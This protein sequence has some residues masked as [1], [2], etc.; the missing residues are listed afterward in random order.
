MLRVLRMRP[1]TPLLRIGCNVLMAWGLLS[2]AQIGMAA[3]AEPT[4]SPPPASNSLTDSALNLTQTQ[5]RTTVEWLAREVDSWFGDQ[6]FSEGGKVT[7]GEIGW[8]IAKRTDQSATRAFRFTARLR[9]PNL[10]SHKSL[11]IGSDDRREVLTDR[12]DTL[13]RQ[14]QLL[15]DDGRDNTF[16]AGIGA[17]LLDTFDLRAGFRG[18]LKPYVQGRYKQDWAL[19]DADHADFR[20]TFFYSRSDRLGSTT[21]L[22]LRHALSTDLNVRWL[23]AITATQDSRD[24]NWASTIGTYKSW[25]DRKLLSFEAIWNGVIGSNV[26]VAD[27]GLQSRWSQPLYRPDL[28]GE[29]LLGHFWPKPDRDSPRGRAWAVG[30]GVRLRF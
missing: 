24:T 30:T 2:H 5:A 13:S 25:G 4:P 29:V 11:F 27:Y 9:L 3:D 18:G 19:T 22:S 26:T 12:P 23:H 6:P 8:N 15:R 20:Q 10:E 16:F 1:P 7:D 17:A 28:T 14:Q 21:A